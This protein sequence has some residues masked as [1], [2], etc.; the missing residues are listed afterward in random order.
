MSDA[1]AWHVRRQCL[2]SCVCVDAAMPRV[3][4]SVLS[5]VLALTLTS[6]SLSAKAP[7]S[8]PHSATPT[9]TRER[10]GRLVVRNS[11]YHEMLRGN[12]PQGCVAKTPPEA[13]AT[14]NPLLDTPDDLRL[15]VSF[16]VGMDGRVYSPFV[17]EGA[18]ADQARPVLDAVRHWRFR[19]AVC[20]GAPAE[21]EAKV[22]FSSLPNRF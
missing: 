2:G 13:L 11:S 18:S 16:V 19:P 21:F 9:D 5:L 3:L 8:A 22:E 12:A 15:T 1:L 17:L 10:W 7:H 4:Q 6:P 20:N 14:P